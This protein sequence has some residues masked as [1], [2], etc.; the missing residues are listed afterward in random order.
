MS[1]LSTLPLIHLPARPAYRRERFPLLIIPAAPHPTTL[2]PQ[3]RD[4]SD[5]IAAACRAARL[6][7]QDKADAAVDRQAR[8]AASIGTAR[9]R[10]TERRATAGLVAAIL[11]FTALAGMAMATR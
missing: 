7:Q 4:R 8:L 1:D 10:R 5:A 9:R 3:R 2:R 11:L 6:R